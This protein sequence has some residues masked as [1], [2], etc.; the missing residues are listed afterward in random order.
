MIAIF[1]SACA[2]RA[3]LMRLCGVAL[4]AA[5]ASGISGLEWYESSASGMPASPVDGPAAEGWTLSIEYADD[6]E[7]QTLYLDGE[8]QSSRVLVRRDGRLVSS[9]EFDA[10]GRLL[11]RFEY[12]YDADGSPRA[13]YR[14]EGAKS[15]PHVI[16][17]TRPGV[18]YENRRHLEGS[19]NSWRITDMDS[20]GRRSSL[21]ILNSGEEAGK[22]R[23]IRD[24][25]GNLLEL[26]VVEGTEE[27][28]IRYDSEARM[29]EEEILKNGVPVLL[30]GYI[31]KGDKIV[32]VEERGSGLVKIKDTVW[33]GDQ[34]IEEIITIDGV[35]SSK[36]VWKNPNEKT[37]TLY[38]N[39]KPFV[40]RHWKDGR[41]YKEE[42]L[43]DR[44]GIRAREG[45]L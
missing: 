40:R 15:A 34:K 36:I 16:S 21:R 23:W 43:G 30:R 26:L 19:E 37:E 17:D 24:S 31:W 25:E 44:E 35:I 28:R 42:Y 3:L 18:D 6:T 1:N 14:S 7:T 11:R 38:R 10:Q 33:F 8:Q 41:S 39:G 22:T 12:A 5:S 2:S 20:E 9:E 27:H 45:G 4:L 32:R 13:I 29:V